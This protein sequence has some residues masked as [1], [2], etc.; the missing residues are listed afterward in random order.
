M[1]RLALLF[2]LVLV[3]GC[4]SDGPSAVAP[5]VVGME[6][7]YPPFETIAKDG[8]PEGVSVEIARAL[9]DYLQR[10]LRI[11]NLPFV[12]L[13]PALTSG[14]IDCVI[15]SMT[16]TDERRRS[17]AF[18]DPYLQI[19]LG[20]LVGANSP[21]K[22]VEDLDSADRTIVVKQGTTGEV[23]ARRELRSAKIL[24][25]EKE[26]AAV[27]EIIQGKADAFIYDQMSVWTNWK[28]HPK[29]T[30]ALLKPLQVEEWAIGLRH[31]DEK[32]E[33]DINGFLRSFRADGG[34]ERLS[35]QFL[36]EQKKAFAEQNI[37]FIF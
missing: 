19:G 4:G 18:S 9:A 33:T 35:E 23:W 7:S 20:I 32:L 3:C 1:K 22:G 11:E 27:L 10:P 28:K 13:I 36:R 25:V 15:S 5:L 34:F 26:N 12:G 21:I 17:I 37:P 16:V 2:S 6:L 31:G 8:R 14:Q 24:A 29:K 30:K